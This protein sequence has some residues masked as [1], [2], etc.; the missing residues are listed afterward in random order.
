MSLGLVSNKKFLLQ[1]YWIQL[2]YF[3]FAILTALGHLWLMNF[4]TTVNGDFASLSPEDLAWKTQPIRYGIEDATFIW[5]CLL[6]VNNLLIMASENKNSLTK[7]LKIYFVFTSVIG[8]LILALT[9]V[10]LLIG[11]FSGIHLFTWE[12]LRIP[13]KVC[14]TVHVF[15]SPVFTLIYLF[16]L[17]SKIN[18]FK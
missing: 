10:T 8:S 16:Y 11:V 14:F 1:D 4:L 17:R 2:T 12:I 5:F 9:F 13:I 6:Q 15:V 18:Q 3:L 7:I